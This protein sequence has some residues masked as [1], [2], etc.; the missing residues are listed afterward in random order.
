MRSFAYK[1][2]FAFLLCFLFLCLFC[3]LMKAD[4]E[5]IGDDVVKETVL[6]DRPFMSTRSASLGNALSP[7]VDGI[8]APFLNPAGIGGLHWGKEQPPSVRELYFPMI[9]VTINEQATDFLGKVAS[10]TASASAFSHATEGKR[11][12]G[13]TGFLLDVVLSRFV[14]LVHQDTQFAAYNKKPSFL[15]DSDANFHYLSKLSAGTGFS[16]TN[17][18][19]DFYLGTFASFDSLQQL[20]GIYNYYDFIALEKRTSLLNKKA[21]SLSGVTVNVGSLWVLGPAGRPALAIAIKNLGGLSYKANKTNPLDPSCDPIH[22]EEDLTVGFS[23]SPSWAAG[24]FFNFVIE[25]QKLT[26]SY[27]SLIKKLHT[28][29]ELN[30]GG[31]G[32]EATFGL[33]LGYNISGISAGLSVNLGLLQ[34]QLSSEAVDFAAGNALKTERRNSLVFAVNVLDN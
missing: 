9:S 15:E 7:L 3:P 6:D 17:K 30:L 5:G 26:Q 23:V 20:K 11:L 16:V 4:N 21:Q 1:N 18:D 8:H 33:G 29:V 28:G 31:F 22:R 34:F 2:V 13:R 25:G 27:L 19:E 32:S 10:N 14:F 12:Y 24:R